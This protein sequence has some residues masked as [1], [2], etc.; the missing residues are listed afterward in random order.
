MTTQ[1][2]SVQLSVVPDAHTQKEIENII[3]APRKL[4]EAIEAFKENR[5]DEE[6]KLARSLRELF[7]AS[8]P[9]VVDR[10]MAQY[11]AWKVKDSATAEKI[12]VCEELLPII[13][14]FI[15]ELKATQREALKAAIRHK[16]D[17]L[18]E[19]AKL[20][21]AKAELI[22]DQ[23]ESLTKLLDELEKPASARKRKKE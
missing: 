10:A 11:E 6:S 3:D 17:Q 8:P 20:E 13:E 22:E 7:A 23:I 14:N 19:A 9:N 12:K 15:Q 5:A 18:Q 16:L 4:A 21:I 2:A 1:P